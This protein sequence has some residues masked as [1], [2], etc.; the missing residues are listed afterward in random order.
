MQSF[1]IDDVKDVSATFQKDLN[2]ICAK[3]KLRKKNNADASKTSEGEKGDDNSQKKKE[4]PKSKGERG[5]KN[6]LITTVDQ[7]KEHEKV[8]S[9]YFLTSAGKRN[10]IES[11]AKIVSPLDVEDIKIVKK[12]LEN[13]TYTGF[14][15]KTTF[16]TP[17][18]LGDERIV[19]KNI[20]IMAL[21]P[22]INNEDEDFN[23]H[24]P[25]ANDSNATKE[26]FSDYFKYH[27]FAFQGSKGANINPVKHVAFHPT[28]E[29]TC[30]RA[31]YSLLRKVICDD[32]LPG[33][34]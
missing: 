12:H 28:S 31:Y 19:L 21:Q 14:V 4:K 25:Q 29:T 32:K 34:K 22:R 33:N 9:E 17:T 7:L 24:L 26:K 30:Q 23:Q 20:I 10:H 16:R 27:M 18:L 15:I 13:Q 8:F 5:P 6:V 3:N 2:E 11:Y 1:S